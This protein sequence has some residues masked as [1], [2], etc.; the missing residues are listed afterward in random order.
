[1]HHT[2][3]AVAMG[4][5]APRHQHARVVYAHRKARVL[6]GSPL[7]STAILVQLS[8]FVQ[9]GQLARQPQESV[10]A[11]E[12]IASM[13]TDVRMRLALT[14]SA[15]VRRR[16]K[17]QK[18]RDNRALI[19]PMFYRSTG[20]IPLHAKLGLRVWQLRQRWHLWW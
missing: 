20:R 4:P 2:R 17:A 8:T 3:H 1:M 11:P 18:G 5:V 16:S 13:T 9:E 12:H 7:E 19:P 15:E 14:V 6:R 10:V